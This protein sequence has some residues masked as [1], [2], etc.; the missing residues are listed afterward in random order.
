MSALARLHRHVAVGGKIAVGT[1]LHSQ[2]AV[3]YRK[4]ARPQLGGATGEMLVDIDRRR[5]HVAL[6]QEHGVGLAARLL[7]PGAGK[8]R[9]ESE[10][11][12]QGATTSTRNEVSPS[13]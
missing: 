8:K 5:R 9:Q 2:A 6:D 1:P 13:G 3:P 10:E 7:R 11:P 12:H 4:A